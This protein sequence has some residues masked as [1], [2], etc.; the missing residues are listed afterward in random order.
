MPIV[1]S[2]NAASS[3][4]LVLVGQAKCGVAHLMQGDFISL[5]CQREDCNLTTRA[6]VRSRVH[7]HHDHR[8][9]GNGLSGYL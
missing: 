1:I 9:L 5:R 8:V 6:T 7:H 3:P 4:E 2:I